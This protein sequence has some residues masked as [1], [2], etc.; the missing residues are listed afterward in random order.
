MP[1]KQELNS[2]Y[3]TQMSETDILIALQQKVEKAEEKIRTF[4][5]GATR[6][7]VGDKLSYAGFLSPLAL[8]RYAQYMHK[9]RKQEDGSIRSSRN[10]RKGIPIEA[11]QDSMIRHMV[12]VW[13]VLE[14]F[15]QAASESDMEELLS[16]II[17][18]AQGLLHELIIKSNNYDR[19][20]TED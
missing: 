15:P 14:G 2:F 10:W 3:N 20:R 1:G 7:A 19:G 6:S 12:D 4:E 8:K 9:H 18:N 11:F 16:A 17:F 5:T 13:L